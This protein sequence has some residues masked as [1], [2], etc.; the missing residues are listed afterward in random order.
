[1]GV[2]RLLASPPKEVMRQ[3]PKVVG[4]LGVGGI[5]PIRTLVAS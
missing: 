2:T 5:G 3:V 4:P 1:M